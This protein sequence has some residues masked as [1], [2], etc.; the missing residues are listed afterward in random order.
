MPRNSPGFGFNVRM[1]FNISI[2]S[3]AVPPIKRASRFISPRP[4]RSR[5]SSSMAKAS[6][7]KPCSTSCNRRQSARSR[8]NKPVGSKVC[9]FSRTASASSSLLPLASATSATLIPIQPVG[10]S[11]L[12]KCPAIRRWRG[13]SIIRLS[14]LKRFG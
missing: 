4:K 13:S 10:S 2:T 1:V 11:A 3:S 12:T 9:N 8:A 5:L 6:L 7:N 14:C